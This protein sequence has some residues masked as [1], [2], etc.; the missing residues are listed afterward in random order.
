MFNI[1]FIGLLPLALLFLLL[2]GC[3]SVAPKT[4][5]PSN[6]EKLNQKRY[7]QA[8]GKIALSAKNYQT[9]ASFDWKQAGGNYTLRFFGPFGYGSA[10][11]IKEGRQVSFEDQEHGKKIAASPEELMNKAMGWQVPIT[12]L[13]HWIKG[14]PA[15][16]ASVTASTSDEQGN[17]LTLDQLGWHLIYSDYRPQNGWTLPGKLI[18]TRENVKV[19][20]VTKTWTLEAPSK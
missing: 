8:E 7:W 11:L 2:E 19:V 6:S 10:W 17:L 18:A 1:R 14:I 16:D 5:S 12:E 3:Q 15:P 9:N 4:T 20:M 13:Q